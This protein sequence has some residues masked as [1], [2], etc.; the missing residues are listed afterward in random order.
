MVWNI[1]LAV[2]STGLSMFNSVRSGNARGDQL[3]AKADNSLREADMQDLSTELYGFNV[4]G[5]KRNAAL[6]HTQAEIERGKAGL[7]YARERLRTS[8]IYDEG[9]KILAANRVFYA[10]NNLD[11]TTGSPL[12]A[13]GQTAARVK[14]DVDMSRVTGIIEA[15]D[16]FTRG[17][18]IEAAAAGEEG[19]ALSASY[20]KVSSAMKAESLRI[21]SASQR[22]AADDERSAG[23]LGA[24]SALLGGADTIGRR[25]PG[26]FSLD[27]SPIFNPASGRGG[28]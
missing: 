14:M 15:T 23:W 7:A 24:A 19:K 6:L 9:E 5:A 18:N 25:M 13:M 11:E 10:G 2:A 28:G 8:K 17:S 26:N 27:I 4:D 16:A 22:E 12:I 3:D 20:S 1:A 21:L